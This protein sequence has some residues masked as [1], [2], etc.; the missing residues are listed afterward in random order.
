MGSVLVVEL[1]TATPTGPR[2][3]RFYT[4]FIRGRNVEFR[5]MR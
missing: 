5:F 2:S 4:R 3:G 1:D